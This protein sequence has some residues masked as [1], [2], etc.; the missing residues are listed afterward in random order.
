LLLRIREV[1]AASESS[2]KLEKLY[3]PP[4]LMI[5]YIEVEEQLFD[6]VR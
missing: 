4:L 6:V 1:A 2:R 3:D 5:V